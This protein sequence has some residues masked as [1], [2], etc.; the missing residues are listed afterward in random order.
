VE[1]C[2]GARADLGTMMIGLGYRVDVR[3]L[4]TGMVVSL[5]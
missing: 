3:G 1:L 2:P 5:V 4:V